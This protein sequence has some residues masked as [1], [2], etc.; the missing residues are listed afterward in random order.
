MSIFD[1]HG[2][3]TNAPE[4]GYR[5]Q[6]LQKRVTYNKTSTLLPTHNE[7]DNAIEQ[8]RSLGY[9]IYPPGV[10]SWDNQNYISSGP[11]NWSYDVNVTVNSPPIVIDLN[12]SLQYPFYQI[13]SQLSTDPDYINYYK[14]V[15]CI[16]EIQIT[17]QIAQ[18][19]D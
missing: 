8:L 15:I 13:I 7:Q 10:Y 9:T 14:L 6:I 17:N 5:G 18:G 16:N 3:Y 12:N 4:I 19:N 11:I 2:L 1:P